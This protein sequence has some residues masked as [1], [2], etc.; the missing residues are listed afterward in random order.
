MNL[1]FDATIQGAEI[2]C[3]IGSDIALS[4][5]VLCFSLM[6]QPRVVS[7]GTMLR[8]LAGYGEVALPDIA[9]G[10]V[11]RLI[12]AHQDP[13]YAP[14]NRAWLPLGAYLRT[15]TG[16]HPLPPLPAGV[17]ADAAPPRNAA[18][19]TG[20]PIAPQP[21]QWHPAPG[22][23]RM[24]NLAT[25]DAAF[26]QVN[27]LA[28]RLTLAPIAGITGVPISIK[29][30]SDMAKD[31]YHL[32]IAVD[33][34]TLMAADE[35]AAFC[36]AITLLNLRETCD[37]ALPCGHIID[38]PRFA[39]RGQH[40]DCARHFYQ[41][42]TIL[43][44]LDLMAL[45]K[46]NRFHWH[47]SDDEAFRL[48]VNC[49]PQIWQQT[50]FRG[51]GC[52]VPGVFGGGIRSGGSY[53]RA[54]VTRVLAHAAALRIEVLP[55]IEVPAHGFALNM[56]HLGMRDPSDNGSEVSVQ[57]Y[58]LN[59]INPAL[60]ATWALIEP[61]CVEVAAMFPLGMLHLG[62]DEL[63]HGA[64]SASPRVAA[65]MKQHDLHDRDDIQ[66]WMMARLAQASAP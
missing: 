38:A 17:H 65:L 1:T 25:T 36:A 51:E 7:G 37:G 4:A 45:F 2:R 16:C 62:C 40:L 6:A 54:D 20:L 44:L 18:P 61:L 42:D 19:F 23:L 47:F 58:P 53:S 27:A 11:H 39:W 50:E 43:R 46:L 55:E 30:V 64:W 14:K 3:E 22:V 24:T 63:P 29:Y 21:S 13:S 28:Q 31:A 34:I 26:A 41:V 56:A 15:K 10:T 60:E 35:D 66:G 12:L 5:P 9:P 52:V 49:A 59:V 8:T 48:Q 32:T 33:H 57:G